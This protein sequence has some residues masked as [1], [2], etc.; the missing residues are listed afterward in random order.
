MLSCLFKRTLRFCTSPLVERPFTP[1]SWN[2]MSMSSLQALPE[3][4]QLG[5]LLQAVRLM[6]AGITP[7]DYDFYQWSC[8]R[9]VEQQQRLSKEEIMMMMRLGNKYSIVLE[10]FQLH[11]HN[12]IFLRIHRDYQNDLHLYDQTLNKEM[13]EVMN[14]LEAQS[15]DYFNLLN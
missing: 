9:V 7:F 11:I 6:E 13:A 12:E 8:W 5:H 14:K 15:K 10:P 3:E 2:A 1:S 4:E